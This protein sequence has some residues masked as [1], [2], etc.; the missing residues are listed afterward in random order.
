MYDGG[1]SNTQ[2]L[3]IKVYPIYSKDA[4]GVE[5]LTPDQQ[6]ANKEAFDVLTAGTPAV[7]MLAEVGITS[8]S[9]TLVNNNLASFVFALTSVFTNEAELTNLTVMISS[10]GSISTEGTNTIRVSEKEETYSLYAKYGA[11][12]TEEQQE[13]NKITFNACLAHFEENTKSPTVFYENDPNFPLVLIGGDSAHS[14]FYFTMKASIGVEEG[15]ELYTSASITLFSDGSSTVS[16][17]DNYTVPTTAKVEEM[18]ATKQDTLVSGQ[19]ISTINGQSLLTGEDI[20]L[21]LDADAELRLLKEGSTDED[22]EYNL[23]TL[24]LVQQGKAV[25]YR[26]LDGETVTYQYSGDRKFSSVIFSEDYMTTFNSFI[27]LAD[28]GRITLQASLVEGAFIL[29][30]AVEFKVWLLWKAKAEPVG[31]YRNLYVLE[32]STRCWVDAYEFNETTTVLEYNCNNKRYKRTYTNETGDF[33]KEELE[34]SS[35]V[36]IDVDSALSST[37]ENPVQN[38]VITQVIT[39]IENRL[40]ELTNYDDTIKKSVQDL[41]TALDSLINGGTTE[42]IDSINEILAFLSTIADTDTLAGIVADLKQYVDDKVA[43]GG[44][45]ITE[46]KEVYIG[47]DEPSDAK[48]WIDPNAEKIKYK[49]ENETWQEIAIEGGGVTIV[50]NLESEDTTAALSANQGRVLKEMVEKLPSGG[51][52]SIAV[53]DAL[54]LESANPVQNKVLTEVLEGKTGFRYLYPGANDEEKAYNLETLRML[55]A[56]FKGNLF[57]GEPDSPQ[58][59]TILVASL[60]EEQWQ[61]ISIDI[62]LIGG[63]NAWYYIDETGEQQIQM[64]ESAM[65][66]LLYNKVMFP[67]AINKDHRA[68]LIEILANTDT[69]QAQMYTIARGTGHNNGAIYFAWKAVFGD[70]GNVLGAYA[71]YY[72]NGICIDAFNPDGSAAATITLP[73]RVGD[74]SIYNVYN[75]LG[76]DFLRNGDMNVIVK[77]DALAEYHPISIKPVDQY[78][79]YKGYLITILRDLKLETYLLLPDGSFTLDSEVSLTQTI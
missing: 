24:E 20:Q 47:V 21:S 8:N 2:D 30:T 32:D 63:L 25:A 3:G 10:D 50:D 4:L 27:E 34:L 62:L 1:A 18:L 13:I 69:I 29:T 45:G 55:N 68:K 77:V 53:D 79:S 67:F 23:K 61:F 39:D 71:Y 46:E 44:G 40:S 11:S 15:Q 70:D 41:Q 59:N 64:D 76:Y 26:S 73:I 43:S 17:I 74:S 42:A 75:D 33:V 14:E 16:N 28:D 52:G 7:F 48:V 49:D 38:K 22:K 54:S 51:G 37:S 78:D 9:A 57:L 56:G 36:T 65:E 72:N 66:D 60:R 5:S 35:N 31:T 19:N 58:F 6:N 12:I